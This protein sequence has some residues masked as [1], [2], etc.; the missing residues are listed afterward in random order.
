MVLSNILTNVRTIPQKKNEDMY[1]NATWKQGYMAEKIAD[2]KFQNTRIKRLTTAQ[3]YADVNIS[4]PY[5][6]P[7]KA[8]LNMRLVK[9]NNV[10]DYITKMN[11][12]EREAKRF[13]YYDPV[14]QAPQPRGILYQTKNYGIGI[15]D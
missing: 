4:M 3:G 9:E 11:D 15:M 10:Y 1:E 5:I 2:R 7:N 12:I 14:N 13:N 6:P 8:V